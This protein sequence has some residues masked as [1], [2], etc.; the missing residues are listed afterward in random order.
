MFPVPESPR[1][2]PSHS[3]RATLDSSQH[4]TSATTK[5]MGSSLGPGGGPAPR[6]LQEPTTDCDRCQR[7]FCLR[8]GSHTGHDFANPRGLAA[9]DTGPGLSR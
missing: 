7:S 1:H 8:H 6:C 3:N 9:A 4:A 5:S 2:P